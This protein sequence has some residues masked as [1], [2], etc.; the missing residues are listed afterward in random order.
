MNKKGFTLIELMI[1][2]AI[3]GLIAAIAVPQIQK[4][5]AKQSGQATLNLATE[6]A[7]RNSTVVVGDA[8]PTAKV[9][10]KPVDSEWTFLDGGLIKSKKLSNDLYLIDYEG[11]QYIVY[12]KGGI[13]RHR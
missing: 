13:A 12:T 2:V 8:A 9:E 4:W 3:M 6:N 7:P 11:Y 10:V 1:V 5:R